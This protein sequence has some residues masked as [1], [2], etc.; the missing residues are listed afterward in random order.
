MLRYVDVCTFFPQGI[1]LRDA[2]ICE[3]V[4]VIIQ[5]VALVHY[6]K[7]ILTQKAF[8]VAVAFVLT[9]GTYDYS[10]QSGLSK[11]IIICSG[12]RANMNVCWAS[13]WISLS[14]VFYRCTTMNFILF[15]KDAPILTPGSLFL[16]AADSYLKSFSLILSQ[17][18]CADINRSFDR[19]G[20]N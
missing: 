19:F 14:S 16:R 5:V 10:F 6:I 9:V 11:N 1:W 7:R 20:C 4:F 8:R 18:E 2:P 15:A 13:L 3:Q 17:G 12:V